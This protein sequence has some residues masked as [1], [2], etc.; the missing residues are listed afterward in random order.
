MQQC[1]CHRVELDKCCCGSH[2]YGIHCNHSATRVLLFAGLLSPPVS[3]V[4]LRRQRMTGFSGF[5]PMT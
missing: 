5:Q 1:H 4:M 3:S 2:A